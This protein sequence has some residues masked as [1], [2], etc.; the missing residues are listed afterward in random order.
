MW[1]LQE[2][3][4]WKYISR[5]RAKCSLG[6]GE[7]FFFSGR[8]SHI[9]SHIKFISLLSEARI[10]PVIFS[11]KEMHYNF[12]RRAHLAIPF[13]LFKK[14]RLFSIHRG[15][16]LFDNSFEVVLTQ[17]IFLTHWNATS[18]PACSQGFYCPWDIKFNS[19][20]LIVQF[21]EVDNEIH[22]WWKGFLAN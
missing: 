21:Q 22:M 4:S 3:Y 17:L 18:T 9:S 5:S 12:E 15:K 14:K 10:E 7:Y 8:C 20:L 1:A 19:Q 2:Y 6:L 11:Q 16:M 13:F